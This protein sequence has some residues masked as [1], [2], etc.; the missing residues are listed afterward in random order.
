MLAQRRYGR[1]GRRRRRVAVAQA[2]SGSPP[3][4]GNFDVCYRAG[5]SAGEIA[6]AVN[7]TRQRRASQRR[8]PEVVLGDARPARDSA[9][10]SGTSTYSFCHLD[11]LSPTRP[12][13]NA[14]IRNSPPSPSRPA[15]PTTRQMSIQSNLPEARRC[16]P[17][18]MP[19]AKTG[20]TAEAVQTED[21]TTGRSS[22]TNQNGN[23][24]RVLNNSYDNTERRQ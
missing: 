12:T 7:R 11:R 9:F 15:V 1:R 24:L 2:T 16:R 5:A 3:A 20:F 22:C 10:N 21:G 6:A 13:P 23:D 4:A 17:S 14:S 18:T 19:A 8:C